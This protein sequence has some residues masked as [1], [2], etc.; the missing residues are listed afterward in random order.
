MD[1]VKSAYHA[2]ACA[3]QVPPHF[4]ACTGNREVNQVSRTLGRSS[5][6]T[7]CD[8]NTAGAHSLEKACGLYYQ[9]FVSNYEE[10]LTLCVLMEYVAS[11]V[12]NEPP[13]ETATDKE[14]PKKVSIS[15]LHSELPLSTT[16]G[17]FITLRRWTLRHTPKIFSRG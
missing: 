11:E 1:D 2:C 16:H 15:C 4:E 7:G 10:V 5:K 9:G 3:V 8:G 14:V 17:S 13:I 6:G 12:E